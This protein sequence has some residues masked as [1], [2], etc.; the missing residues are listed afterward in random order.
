MA[1]DK[2]S[3]RWF[4]TEPEHYPTDPAQRQIYRA[5]KAWRHDQFLVA[6][7]E[8]TIAFTGKA[9]TDRLLEVFTPE[10]L[11]AEIEK[12][13]LILHYQPNTPIHLYETQ[14]NIKSSNKV[15]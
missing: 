8:L 1:Q 11:A 13:N 14:A 10:E 3:P 12:E 4:E 15:S 9:P 7:V 5:L 6:V 2:R